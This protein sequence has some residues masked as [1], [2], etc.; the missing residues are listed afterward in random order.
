M[1]HN[2]TDLKSS[3]SLDTLKQVSSLY[4]KAVHWMLSGRPALPSIICKIYNIVKQ[5]FL[6]RG[7]FPTRGEFEKCKGGCLS[8]ILKIQNTV[9]YHVAL[10]G[11]PTSRL[12]SEI[13]DFL[14]TFLLIFIFAENQNFFAY[15]ITKPPASTLKLKNLDFILQKLS[16][17]LGKTG[18]NWESAPTQLVPPVPGQA[19][20]L[21]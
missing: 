4:G 10:S 8:F 15:P 3:I 5:W 6:T 20:D 21:R 11:L 13:S 9:F 16:V 19:Y 12:Q 14:Q 18:K 1:S 2:E 7:E 17:T